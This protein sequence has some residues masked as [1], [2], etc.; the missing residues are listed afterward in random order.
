MGASKEEEQEE[1]V[2][3]PD[4][5]RAGRAVHCK[6]HLR[7]R[8]VAAPEGARPPWRRPTN[9]TRAGRAGRC[10]AHLRS[11]RSSARGGQTASEPRGTESATRRGATPSPSSDSGRAPR[12]ACSSGSAAGPASATCTTSGSRSSGSRR[13]PKCSRSRRT[14]R[15]GR[16]SGGTVT[17]APW[18]TGRARA[19][20]TSVHPSRVPKVA[21]RSEHHSRRR[22]PRASSPSAWPSPSW[23]ARPS[24]RR[25]RTWPP[26]CCLGNVGAAGG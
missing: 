17:N 18:R 26:T 7:S 10:R 2:G 8:P 22:P 23:R 1:E 13:R 16:D 9:A 20:P 21:P 19:K 4:A 3:R 24:E 14:H 6:G 5:R 11:P 15:K 12:C 25:T